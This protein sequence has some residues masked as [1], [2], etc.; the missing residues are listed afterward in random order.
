MG[1]KINSSLLY[2]ITY[3]SSKHL[4]LKSSEIE[5]SIEFRISTFSVE[6]SS[7]VQYMTALLFIL[8]VTAVEAG[9]FIVDVWR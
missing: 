9:W 3:M 5:I 6:Y 1:G 2:S 4:L 8:I 7:F